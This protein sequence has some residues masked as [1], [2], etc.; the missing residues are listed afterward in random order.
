MQ[1]KILSKVVLNWFPP[2]GASK[3]RKRRRNKRDTFKC[4]RRILN[5]LWKFFLTK[6]TRRTDFPNVILFYEKQI[7]YDARSHERKIRVLWKN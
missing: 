1:E 4:K 7:C 2:G 3:S 6:P 5:I